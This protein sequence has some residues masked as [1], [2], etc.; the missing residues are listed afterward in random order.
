MYSTQS[1]KINEAKTEL[2]A[3]AD[4]S[5]IIVEDFNTL[6]SILDKGER[7]NKENRRLK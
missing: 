5:I 4:I 2:E 6:L 1:F 3:E 7:I